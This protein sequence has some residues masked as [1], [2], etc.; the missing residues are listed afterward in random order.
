MNQSS[1]S[2]AARALQPQEAEPAKA[3]SLPPAL[4]NGRAALVVAHPGHELRVHGW[5]ELAHPLV[6]VLTDGSG[7]TGQSRLASTTR[8]LAQSGARPGSIYGRFKDAEVYAAILDNNTEFFIELAEELGEALAR[9]AVEY[10]VGDAIEGY[11]PLHD[12]C[13]S[14]INAAV[15][16]VNSVKP[17]QIANFD[18][19]VVGQPEDSRSGEPGAQGVLLRLDE[20]ALARKL[21]AAKLYLELSED[22]GRMTSEAGGAALQL[23]SLRPVVGALRGDGHIQ[24]PPFYERYGEKQVAQGYY[25]RVIRYRGHILPLVDALE[26]HARR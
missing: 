20:V 25:R 8:L 11:N 9:E 13:R 4:R 15:E 2:D 1:F 26:N 21:A 14:V 17:T 24:E 22:V 16:L 7:H 5:M 10:V 23:E 6:C 19:L 3:Y 18:F 12:L